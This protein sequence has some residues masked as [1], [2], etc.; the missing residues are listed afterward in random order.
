MSNLTVEQRMSKA[1]INLM[2]SRKFVMFSG[3]L[4]I[5]KCEVRDD[6]P[7]ACTNG[8]DEKWGRKFIESMDDKELAFVVIH[9]TMHK[10]YK[11]FLIYQSMYREN[12]QLANNACDYVIN[13]ELAEFDKEGEV[14]KM[15]KAGLLDKRFKGMNSR[16]VYDILKKE[17]Q[18]NNDSSK[19][20][21]GGKG[22]DEHDWDGAE[23]LSDVERVALKNEIDNA[24]R[25]G[26]IAA[27]KL[28]G[29]GESHSMLGISDLLAPKV[30]W[31]QQLMDWATQVVRGQD[32]SSWRRVNRR[33][34]GQDTYMPGMVRTSVKELV[35][36]VDTSGSVSQ[37]ELTRFL[38]EIASMCDTLSPEKLHIMYWD[39]SVEKHEIYE[40]HNTA[41]A[42]ESTKPSGG[43]GTD[44]RC[45]QT[46]MAEKKITPDGVIIF[47][48]GHISE[49]GAGWGRV[50]WCVTDNKEALAPEGITIH[51]D[52]LG[53]EN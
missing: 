33:Y 51:V 10:V 46:H 39:S 8:R 43:G 16:Q 20:Q 17:R 14:I 45:V 4:T 42:V 30:D 3:M 22:F 6:I 5:G 38:S 53:D 23:S 49:W 48:D 40:G 37:Q 44:P 21:G 34:L 52:S 32:S 9:E 7:T 27:N 36:A 12:P 24:L 11:H 2:R 35:L 1:R 28:V 15:P 47:T 25:Q 50:I 31:R 19:D 18:D 41:S 13:L 29:E 26:Q